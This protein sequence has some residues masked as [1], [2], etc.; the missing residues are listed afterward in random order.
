MAKEAIQA[1]LQA[2]EE[3]EALLKEARDQ[4]EQVKSQ[5]AD[6][7]VLEEK[8]IREQIQKEEDDFREQVEAQARQKVQTDLDRA[9]EEKNYWLSLSDADL[10]PAVD[11][12]IQEVIHYGDR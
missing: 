4:A 11:S 7:L 9:E 1:V 8:Q 2:E 10:Q 6:E 3:A 12:V 5:K